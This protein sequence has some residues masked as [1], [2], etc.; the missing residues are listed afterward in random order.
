MIKNKKKQ[1]KKQ[2]GEGVEL[3]TGPQT[4][5]GHPKDWTLSEDPEGGAM[6][7]QTTATAYNIT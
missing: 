3:W 7:L 6:Q 2:G 4:V 1:K 5:I